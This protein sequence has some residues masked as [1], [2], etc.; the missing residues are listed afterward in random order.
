MLCI[1]LSG[2]AVTSQAA[3]DYTLSGTTFTVYT[4]DGLMEVARIINGESGDTSVSYIT[5][6][7]S[8]AN[9]IDMSGNTWKPIGKND[10]YVYTGTVNGNGHTISNLKRE[11][12]SSTC[13]GFIGVAGLNVTV[14]NLNLTGVVLTSN[15]EGTAYAGGIIGKAKGAG[16]M[17]VS[18]CTVQ[19]TVGTNLSGA[20]GIVG[21]VTSIHSELTVSNCTVNADIVAQGGDAGSIVGYTTS[22]AIVTKTGCKT[23][24]G[25]VQS[26]TTFTVYTADA[27]MNVAAKVNSDTAYSAAVI[28]IGA[29]IDMSGKKWI[30]IGKDT[31]YKFGGTVNGGGYTVS[32]LTAGD[33]TASNLAFVGVAS[34]G[35]TVKDLHLEN[36]NF[37]TSGSITAGIIANVTGTATITGCTVEG[38]IYA[39]V[40]YA[41]GLVGAVSASSSDLTITNCAVDA[42]ICAVGHSA[43][44]IVG[45][46]NATGATSSDLTTYPTITANKVFLTGNFN[47]NYR[48]GSFVGYNNCLNVDLRN[49]ISLATLSYVQASENGAFI[50]VDNYSKIYLENCTV[51]SDLRAFYNLKMTSSVQ[52][53]ELNNCYLLKDKIGKQATLATYNQYSYFKYDTA[54]TYKYK[55]IAD[56]IVDGVGPTFTPFTTSNTG[57]RPPII[58]Y[59]LPSGTETEVLARAYSDAMAMFTNGSVQE[60]FVHKHTW[61]SGTVKTAPTYTST[62]TTAYECTVCHA[63][64]MAETPRKESNVTWTFDKATKTLTISGV[65]MMSEFATPNTIP[66][67]AHRAEISTVIIEKGIV[68]ICD[69][70]FYDCT[71]LE[72][73]T[74]PSGVTL[75][76]AYSFHNCRSLRSVTLPSTV[77]TIYN[78]AFEYCS[79]LESINIPSAVTSIGYGVFRYAKYA[80]PVITSASSKYAVN[81]N[82]LIEVSTKTVKAG[83]A[84]STI[85]TDA[86]V[87]AAIGRGAFQ[88]CKVTSL[89]IPSNITEIG[90][91]AFTDCTALKSL[92][93]SSGLTSIADGTFSG[94]PCLEN[95]VI[96]SAVAS[97]GPL[98]FNECTGLQYVTLPSS[99]ASID[100]SAFRYCTSLVKVTFNGSSSQWSAV[101]ISDGNELLTAKAV[102][103]NSVAMLNDSN[104][105]DLKSFTE[106]SAKGSEK[107]KNV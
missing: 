68:D 49:C 85:P 54:Q 53:V 99:L 87:A 18:G 97:I 38:S 65:G 44:G 74:I 51:F 98:A 94:C 26:G 50:A 64:K 14:K 34:D 25:S 86:T 69:Y 102:A 40:N 80:T 90:I 2:V 17:T 24:G 27:L 55:V 29:N 30:P 15:R 77:K 11:N 8:I 92:S 67:K 13:L 35:A 72:N 6:N 95:L 33:Y 22:G 21:A 48:V 45:G 3:T 7:I 100:I 76:G 61:G 105:Y 20:G 106:R 9:D 84:N 10:T 4:A 1:I 63:V 36:I 43:A 5:Y 101:E 82:C 71:A 91:E 81:G 28:N 73:I 89:T 62:G 66:W 104:E 103:A 58:Q 56:V 60:S 37:K 31:T 107:R 32:N 46:D 52:T 16:A 42:D 12:Y 79:G 23:T 39:G 75:I 78:H 41:G 47:A 19:G 96:P 93:I 57:T 70:A 83:F 59:N 88:G